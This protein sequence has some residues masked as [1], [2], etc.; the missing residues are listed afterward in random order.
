MDD[1][2]PERSAALTARVLD[3]LG[4]EREA[5]PSGIDGT[6]WEYAVDYTKRRYQIGL[7]HYR[8]LFHELGWSGRRHGLDI[9][10]GAGHWAIAFALDNEQATGIDRSGGVRSSRQWGG[11]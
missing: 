6:A 1:F 8:R 10:G 4:R 7:E 9:G 5:R 2:A 3:W 11:G